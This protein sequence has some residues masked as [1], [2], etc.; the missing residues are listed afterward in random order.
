MREIFSSIL[1]N[2]NKLVIILTLIY[3][4]NF[5]NLG[6]TLIRLNS[7]GNSVFTPLSIVESFIGPLRSIIILMRYSNINQLFNFLKFE[8]TNY[9]SPYFYLIIYFFITKMGYNK[10]Y[11]YSPKTSRSNYILLDANI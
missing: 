11:P 8:L 7:D 10:D 4:Y 9:A 3:L 5:N 1:L 6:N 2:K